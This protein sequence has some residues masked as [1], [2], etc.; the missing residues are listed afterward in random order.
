MPQHETA[1]S[2]FSVMVFPTLKDATAFAHELIRLDRRH[3][4]TLHNLAVIHHPAHGAVTLHERNDLSS[5]QGAFVGGA[6]GAIAGLLGG[7]P[8]AGAI[9]G[10]VGGY[11]ASAMLDLG[12]DD[13]ALRAIGEALPVGGAAVAL[14]I[15]YHDLAVALRRLG[16][17]QG[18]LMQNS[19]TPTEAEQLLA[20][21]HQQQQAVETLPQRS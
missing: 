10:T 11:L 20:A 8:V 21:F 1:S 17:Y 7:Q 19:V 6:L 12:F 18:R 3:A 16:R 14:V 4:I 9:V 13:K 2:E 5:S 15:T